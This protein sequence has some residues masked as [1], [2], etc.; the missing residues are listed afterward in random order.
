MAG[1]QLWWLP[2]AN[3][4]KGDSENS[5][6]MSMGVLSDVGSTN[7]EVQRSK[8]KSE[9]VCGQWELTYILRNELNRF[10]G[11]DGTKW[12][13]TIASEWGKQWGTWDLKVIYN[14]KGNQET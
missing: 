6:T 11:K 7:V 1:N 9:M 13:V 3:N 14:L 2:E 12:W 4:I 8:W 10:N 5:N